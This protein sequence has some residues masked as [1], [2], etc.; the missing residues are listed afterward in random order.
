MDNY[1]LK[2]EPHISFC[3]VKHVALKLEQ[4]GDSALGPRIL[5]EEATMVGESVLHC[6]PFKRDRDGKQCLTK[7]KD[8][9]DILSHGENL[10]GQTQSPSL[11]LN[12]GKHSTDNM[13][14]EN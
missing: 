14:E 11:L 12:T 1:Q 10:E 9:L 5:A 4:N 6:C 7:S 3:K 2:K 13:N 8:L